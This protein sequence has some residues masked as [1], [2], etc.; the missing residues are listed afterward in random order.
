MDI[1]DNEVISLS[2]YWFLF[3]PT[4]LKKEAA[5]RFFFF[6]PL[7]V[8]SHPVMMFKGIEEKN[9][10]ISTLVYLL[11]INKVWEVIKEGL[12]FLYD[13]FEGVT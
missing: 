13:E 2:D 9:R 3:M 1:L 7:E 6:F 10:E 12:L 5:L 8:V 4:S 11:S